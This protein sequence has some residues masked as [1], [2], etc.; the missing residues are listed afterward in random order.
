MIKFFSKFWIFGIFGVDVLVFNWKDFNV[1]IVFLVCMVFVVINY[2]FFCRVKGIFVVF[3]WIF[4]CFWFLLVDGVGYFKVFVVDYYEYV[5]LRNFFL[6]G[7]DGKS[8][9]V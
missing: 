8:I 9:F 4:F 2:M 3:K 6:L 1:W 7:F 5:K